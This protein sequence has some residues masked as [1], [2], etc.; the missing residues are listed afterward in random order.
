MHLGPQQSESRTRW[1]ILNAVDY[2][3]IIIENG[4]EQAYL[5]SKGGYELI[6]KIKSVI[7]D[8]IV[9]SPC[10]QL[11]SC[12]SVEFHLW[13]Q[14]TTPFLTQKMWAIHGVVAQI[15]QCELFSRVLHH[16]FRN[17]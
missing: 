8:A 3:Q 15:R 13:G 9:W 17:D 10:F 5:I 11:N 4:A 2:I 14:N 6:G 7:L 1:L 12:R 16:V